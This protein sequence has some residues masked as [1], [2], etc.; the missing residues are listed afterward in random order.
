MALYIA[1]Q[2]LFAVGMII[3]IGSRIM[4][5]KKYMLLLM[6]IASIFYVASYICLKSP[7]SAISN[8]LN[9]IRSF[10][11]LFLEKKNKSFKYFILPIFLILASF[12][13]A[14]VFYWNSLL[15]M[16]II[17]AMFSSTIFLAFKD[18]FIIRIGLTFTITMWAIYDFTLH[19]YV[20][21]ACDILNIIILIFTLIY[22]H[23]ILPKKR[24]LI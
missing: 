9:L 5:N 18:T 7:L 1:S 2:L 21:M 4:K 24:K 14:Q 17:A 6:A 8:G 12:T 13:T 19:A 20:N 3:D 11:Y 23:Y 10:V 15:D 22:Y 16:F